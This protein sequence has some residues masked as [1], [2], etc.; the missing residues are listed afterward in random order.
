LKNFSSGLPHNLLMNER[1][2]GR[3][4]IGSPLYGVGKPQCALRRAWY[5][6][7]SLGKALIG[8]GNYFTEKPIEKFN[9]GLL[10]N[11]SKKTF[12]PE[13]LSPCL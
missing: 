11:S 13:W 1:R 7:A 9:K 6:F 12:K 5:I 4:P 10:W 3:S 2:E 8:E